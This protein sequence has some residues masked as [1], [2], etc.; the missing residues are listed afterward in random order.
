MSDQI[1]VDLRGV[2]KRYDGAIGVRTSGKLNRR[3]GGI[4]AGLRA[5]G[6]GQGADRR[7]Y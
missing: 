2:T 6:R 1:Q 5:R 3:R 4:D 7:K